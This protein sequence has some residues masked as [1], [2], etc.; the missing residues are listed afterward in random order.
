MVRRARWVSERA[1]KGTQLLEF[2][3]ETEAPL[4]AQQALQARVERA[5]EKQ[6]KRVT[7][8]LTLDGRGHEKHVDD[9]ETQKERMKELMKQAGIQVSIKGC[10]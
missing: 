6:T 2:V 10:V 8:E 3:R 9:L 1:Q 4:A 5:L 7:V